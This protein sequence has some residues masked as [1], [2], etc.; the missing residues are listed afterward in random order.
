LSTAPPNKTRK[1][2]ISLSRIQAVDGVDPAPTI[3]IT[4]QTREGIATIDIL[5]DSRSDICAA[6]YD[7]L[8][9]LGEH[10][11]NLASSEI[12]PRAVNGK[13]MSPRGCV[14]ATF[15][16]KGRT[17][18]SPVHIYKDVSGALLSWAVAKDLG[19]LPAHY[20][21]PLPMVPTVNQTS[22]KL[23]SKVK[24]PKTVNN[25]SK[26]DL[27]NEFP[28]VFD[29]VIRTMQGETF[30]IELSEDARP[31]QVTT[32]R[33]IPFPLR[34]KLKAELDLQVKQGIIAP[35]TEP[36]DWCSPIVVAPKKD[37]SKIR[38]CVDLS[39]L[40]K[41]VKRERFQS[42]TPAA[43]VASIAGT[44][45]KWFS[46]ID[47][48]KGYHQTE[49][50]PASQ[51]LTTFITPFGRYK[52]LRGP[53]GVSS[54]SEH[55]DRRM[56]EALDGIEQHRR[57]V[58]DVLIYDVNKDVHVRHVREV[59][60][61]CA[62]K[63]ISLCKEKFQFCE[64]ALEFA[65]FIVS[66]H[67]YEVSPSITKAITNFPPPSSR[68]DLRSFFGLV[69]QLSGSTDAVARVLA[70]LRTLLCSKN[71]FLWDVV[72]DDA[73]A[74]VKE[75]LTS[76]PILAYYDQTLPTRLTTDGSRLGIGFVLQ[77][78]HKG[79][80]RTVQAGSRF[81]TDTESRYA[82]VEIELLAV[83]WAA[84]KCNVFL[85]GLPTFTVVTDHNPLI[86]ILNSHRLDEIENP[87]LQRLRTRLLAYNFIAKWVKGADNAA[88]DSLSR[89][90][91][92]EPKDDDQLA[93][94]DLDSATVKSLSTAEIRLVL[95]P[96]D[97]LRLLELHDVA[98]ADQEYQDLRHIVLEGFPN[99]K[100]ELP[101]MMKQYWKLKD[102]LSVEDDF[103]VF[104]CRLF[105][106]VSYR[107]TILARLHEAHAG[108]VRSQDRARLI[109][110]WPG[111][112]TDIKLFVENC[113]FCQDHLP[114]QPPEPIMSKPR[115]QR[116]FQEI[117][118]DFASHAGRQFL[119]TVDCFS[120]WPD[121]I[122]MGLDTTAPKTI[123]VLRQL[124]CRTAV[125][126]VL[127]SDNGPQFTSH[128]FQAFLKD[129]NVVH[130][131]S[132]P[133][134][135]QSNGKAE[136]AVKSCKK[137]LKASWT[138]KS[139]NDNRLCRA[140]MS[141]R[142][143]PSRRDQL[144]P[145]QK[146]YGHPVQDTLPTHRRSFAPE[147]QRLPADA[148]QHADDALQTAQTYYDQRSHE[149]SDLNVGSHVAVQDHTTKLWDIYGI[150]SEISPHRRYFIRTESGT[151][152]VRN[153]RFLRKRTVL[154]IRGPGP[155]QP[156]PAAPPAAPAAPEQ[157][158][159]P[160]APPDDL[161]RGTRVRTPV[162]RYADWVAPPTPKKLDRRSWPPPR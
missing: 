71:D 89:N 108:I 146:L 112:D 5:P 126:D 130:K 10:K 149:L 114:S 57:I 30:K 142:N 13:K 113:M 11:D 59:L 54:I 28:T 14:Y 159:A 66:Q 153:R 90:P 50:D 103:I 45:A 19:I 124:F 157:P 96:E 129:W 72:H 156:V 82:V 107:P 99:S 49:L 92:D 74:R 162:N 22:T 109:V 24:S 137:L 138:G 110:Y 70:P 44:K 81:L 94:Y 51:L 128:K 147:W 16:L 135:A 115:P 67:G 41:F 73:F 52:Y 53:F 140:L 64:S 17:A 38:L 12:Y 86:P 2:R 120:D 127:W 79:N 1:P 8:P 48:Y 88:A 145:A 58:D 83:A 123:T 97:N 29:G 102:N 132:S 119:I 148:A 151:V 125:P 104:G 111:I 32:P 25:L 80:W 35:V 139:G 78:D 154:S 63:G 43:A 37:T 122:H 87:R 158:V 85:A 121:I 133:R 47:A 4:V 27:I 76:A 6:G 36:T 60:Q 91:C 93:E 23:S 69:N 150:I 20:P 118:V 68:T 77:Q 161:R 98:A 18:Q 134:Y 9:Q 106:P 84:K 131:V 117:A 46:S 61:R 160:L 55:Y 144:S 7:F 101:D 100:G 95:A 3:P 152:L 31:F 42:T 34:D 15:T 56:Y 33:T 136:A 143:T 141:Y 155:V 40:N 116:P 39:K 21:E 26:E 62:D 65:G 105:I 75:V